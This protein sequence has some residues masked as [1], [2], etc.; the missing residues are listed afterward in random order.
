[1]I[2][3]LQHYIVLFMGNSQLHWRFW[4]ATSK[5]FVW[6]CTC[7]QEQL[8]FLRTFEVDSHEK[9]TSDSWA[10]V[11]VVFVDTMWIEFPNTIWISA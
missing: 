3:E 5:P 11:G 8:D 6:L 2:E 10:G 7:I 1:V 9:G 4:H